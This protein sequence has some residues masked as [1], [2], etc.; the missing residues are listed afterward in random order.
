MGE[1]RTLAPVRQIEALAIAARLTSGSPFNSDDIA[2]KGRKGAIFFLSITVDPDTVSILVKIQGKNINGTYYDLPDVDF[3]AQAGTGDFT[4]T[5]YPGVGETAN[6][7]VSQI[8]PEIIRVVSTHTG[9]TTMTYGVTV[10][11]KE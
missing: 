11:F 5:V 2:T 6:E 1:T 3:G 7:A 10:E 9:G 8:L 4:L